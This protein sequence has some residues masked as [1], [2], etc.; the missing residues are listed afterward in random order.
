MPPEID[1]INQR[2]NPRKAT[3]FGIRSMNVVHAMHP[4]NNSINAIARNPSFWKGNKGNKGK[5]VANTALE[6]QTPS[7]WGNNI[8]SCFGITE[9]LFEREERKQINT[10]NW[11]QL[12][13][14]HTQPSREE[15][16]M[17]AEANLSTR[18]QRK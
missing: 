18:N 7:I 17:R 6:H 12:L 1:Q 4:I 9:G 10:N 2:H 8:R 11:S 14:E 16:M 15:P 3:V 5:Y 13:L